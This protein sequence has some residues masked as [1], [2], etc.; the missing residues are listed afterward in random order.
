MKKTTL[1]TFL[2]VL[3]VLFSAWSPAAASSAQSGTDAAA[4]GAGATLTITNPL[5]KATVV[6]L[7]GSNNYTF[8]VSANQTVTK[9]IAVGA[10]RYK[11]QGCLGKTTS[12]ILAYKNGKYELD[13]QPCKMITLKIVNP[14]F[15][16][17]TSTMKGWMNYQITVKPRHTEKFSVVAGTYFLSYTC[18]PSNKNWEGKVKLQKNI[19]WIMCE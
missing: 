9:T 12:G 19:L 8:T 13:I 6:T 18:T 14:F 17:Y 4:A 7:R 16:T 10:Y 1:L 15:D 5:P 3:T 11:Y 2:I